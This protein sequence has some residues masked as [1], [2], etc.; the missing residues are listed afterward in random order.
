MPGQ[1]RLHANN[2]VDA[3]VA[4]EE[5]IKKPNL[6]DWPKRMKAGCGSVS[7]KVLLQ[8]KP[9]ASGKGAIAL[10]RAERSFPCRHGRFG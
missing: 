9:A 5:G 10:A 7:D 6:A 1:L 3:V 2:P 8:G 4:V